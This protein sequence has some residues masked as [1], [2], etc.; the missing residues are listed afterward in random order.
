MSSDLPPMIDA[1]PASTLGEPEPEAVD[2][3]EDIDGEA[4]A[5]PEEM[6]GVNFY[7]DTSLTIPGQSDPPGDCGTWGPKEFCKACGDVHIGP[8]RCQRRL[9]RDCWKTWRAHRAAA[10]TERV[11]GGRRAGLG[12]LDEKRG[13]HC[14][15]SP[16]EGSIRTLVE[17]EKGKQRAY[18]IAREKGIRGG[19]MIPHGWRVRDEAKEIFDAMKAKEKVGDIGIWQWVRENERDWRSLTY[20]SPHFHII[21]VG[22]EIGESDPENDGGWVFSRLSNLP[23]FRYTDSETYKPMFQ[24]ASYLLSHGAYEPNKG[25]QMIRW[26]GKLA[27]NQFS[28]DSQL[29]E[30]EESVIERTVEEVGGYSVERDDGRRECDVEGCHGGLAP[31][32]SA[33]EYLCD[34]RWCEQ[35]GSDQEAVLAVAFEWVVGEIRP[36][37]G[38]RFPSTEQDAKE[39]WGHLLGDAGVGPGS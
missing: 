13:T 22:N 17:F 10:V 30:W 36:P 28:A 31:V 35:I 21:G 23:R 25:R 34:P 29:E 3:Q 11:A 2:V 18:E 12:D 20:W 24:L 14:V 37:P 7:A 26:F 32:W 15:V 33:G 9:C 5:W 38:L 1:R 16:P 39:A 4:G 27:N 8:Q 6:G 19:A